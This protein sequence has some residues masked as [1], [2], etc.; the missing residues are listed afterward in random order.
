M[1]EYILDTTQDFLPQKNVMLIREYLCKQAPVADDGT[2]MNNILLTCPAC[3]QIM[4]RQR[5]FIKHLQYH[6]YSPQQCK[7]ALYNTIIDS[8][9][10]RQFGQQVEGIIEEVA[11]KLVTNTFKQ[12]LIRTDPE[13]PKES[14]IT[15]NAEKG[16]FVPSNEKQSQPENILTTNITSI[17]SIS[18][19]STQMS[20]PSPQNKYVFFDFETT[21]FWKNDDPPKITEYCFVDVLAGVVLYG[22]VNPGKAISS[23]A[24]GITGL[25]LNNLRSKL[26]IESHVNDIIQFLSN[27][28]QGKTYLIAHNGD[29]LDFKVFAKEFFGKF[30]E[31][32]Y[33]KIVFV[34]SL[35]LMKSESTLHNCLPR[36]TTKTGKTKLVFAEDVLIEHFNVGD[37]N[38]SHCAFYDAIGLLNILIKFY[39]NLDKTLKAIECF[40]INQKVGCRCKKGNCSKC[41][42][43]KMGR[44][45]DS[46]CGCN[47][48]ICKRRKCQYVVNVTMMAVGRP[49][50]QTCQH[51]YAIHATN[52]V[53]R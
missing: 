50:I 53:Y 38:N 43:A 51:F 15:Y 52:H 11:T 49:A 7:D 4:V 41:S 8:L 19:N 14:F 16:L 28:S 2:I 31:F 37:V 25:N 17:G 12:I 32:N 48:E 5:S 34:D 44:I 20:Q 30:P 26:P 39:G 40:K 10:S 46:T 6:N 9:K 42:C 24:Q 21:G 45:C 3:N 36:K 35:Q 1:Y 29:C 13:L 22:L 33:D 18:E 27:N 47:S 23:Q